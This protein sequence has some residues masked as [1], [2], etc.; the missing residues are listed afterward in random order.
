[1]RLLTSRAAFPRLGAHLA[2]TAAPRDLPANLAAKYLSKLSMTMR[3][4]A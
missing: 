2:D 4:H 3:T 1:M